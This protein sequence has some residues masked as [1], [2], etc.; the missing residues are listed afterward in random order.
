MIISNLSGVFLGLVSSS[1]YYWHWLIVSCAFTYLLF[2]SIV[3][4][5][6]LRGK[7]TI[8]PSLCRSLY[9]STICGTVGKNKIVL[10]AQHLKI[11]I[12]GSN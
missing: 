12:A 9:P 10:G 4:S 11:G 6:K 5:L 7:V 2:I 1:Y 8:W 3:P